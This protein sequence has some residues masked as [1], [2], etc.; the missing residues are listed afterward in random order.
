MIVTSEKELRLDCEDVK[1]EEVAE[2]RQKLEA[3]VYSVLD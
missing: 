1:P 2:L 3:E